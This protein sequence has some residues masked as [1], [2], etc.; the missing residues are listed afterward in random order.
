MF[1]VE[2]ARANFFDRPAVQRAMTA[3]ARR[4]LSRFGAF[5]MTR[6]R[7]SI[8]YAPRVYV[9][10]GQI[11]RGRPRRGAAT[12]D[13]TSAPGQIPYAHRSRGGLPTRRRRNPQPRS[14]AASPLRE[15][16]YFGFDL[17]R[18][19]V[20]IGPALF[21]GRRPGAPGVGMELLEWGGMGNIRQPGGMGRAARYPERP[22]MR[23]AFNAELHRMP[24][25]W[26]DSM[27]GHHDRF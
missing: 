4:N 8:R 12:V 5:V 22:F 21:P 1:T 3:A 11:V 27:R 19:S 26:R 13:D 16:L 15:L 18:Q 2:A 23:P 6:A 24:Q 9:A 25:L 14:R 20:V 10:T 7:T 17:I